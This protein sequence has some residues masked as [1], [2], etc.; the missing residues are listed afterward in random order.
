VAGLLFAPKSG[1]ELRTDIKGEG[2]KAIREAKR[3][4]SGVRGKADAVLGSAKDILS[5]RERGNPIVLEDLEE[6]EEFTAE[7]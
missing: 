7:A 2:E 6:P 4:Y 5:G 3:L 1:R